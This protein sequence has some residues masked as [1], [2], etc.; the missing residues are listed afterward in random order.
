MTFIKLCTLVACWA[1]NVNIW[2]EFYNLG[3]VPQI[4]LFGG[5]LI[6]DILHGFRYKLVVHTT[7][8]SWI[9]TLEPV[10]IF[11]ILKY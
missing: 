8:I 10:S 1:Q 2:A 4:A 9:C 5:P 11:Y 3:W 6:L 7:Q